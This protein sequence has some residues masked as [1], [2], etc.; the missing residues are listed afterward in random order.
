[1]NSS[2]RTPSGEA[3]AADG[4]RWRCRADGSAALRRPHG[5]AMESGNGIF[6][7]N[8]LDMHETATCQND[9]RAELQNATPCYNFFI[10][11]PV[12]PVVKFNSS[13]PPAFLGKKL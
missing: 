10:R 11:I 7:L 3:A 6:V 12:S 9:S 13:L 2:G 8:R 5:T 4:V 1:M